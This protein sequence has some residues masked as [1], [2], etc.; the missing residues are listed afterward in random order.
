L[1]TGLVQSGKVNR[2]GF[3]SR[4][5]HKIVFLDGDAKSGVLVATSGN[6]FRIALN[7]TKQTIRIVSKGKVEIEAM[8]DVSIKSKANVSV[9]AAAKMDLKAT[10]GVTIDGGPEV[11]IKGGV[12]KLN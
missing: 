10:A 6:G 1:G 9:T 8:Q 2:R 3:L 4:K 7:E 11:V 5:G 12:I